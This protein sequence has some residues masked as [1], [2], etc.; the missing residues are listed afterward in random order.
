VSE[1]EGFELAKERFRFEDVWILCEPPSSQA[2]EQMLRGHLSIKATSATFVAV[3]GEP[4]IRI[5]DVREVSLGKKGRDWFNTWVE[6]RYGSQASPEVIFSNDGRWRGWYPILRR[7]NRE[8][9]RVL[10]DLITT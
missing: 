6:V 8:I 3:G 7:S 5:R 1:D 2:M 4:R 9:E 10:Q